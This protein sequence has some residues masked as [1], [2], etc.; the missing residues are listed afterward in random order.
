MERMVWTRVR[1]PVRRTLKRLHG[2][3]QSVFGW[4]NRHLHQYRIGSVRIATPEGDDDRPPGLQD[5]G[6]WTIADVQKSRAKEFQYVYDFGDRWQHRIVIE[7]EQRTG[8]S[9]QFAPLCLAGE[10]RAAGGCRRAT[11]L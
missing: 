4:E 5:E 1:V 9:A 11:G 8:A 7:P 6:E 3:I 2:L 10:R